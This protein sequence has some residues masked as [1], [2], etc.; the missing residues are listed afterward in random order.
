MSSQNRRPVGAPASSGGQFAQSVR[1]ESPAADQPLT[2]VAADDAR[3]ANLDDYVMT[4]QPTACPQCQARSVNWEDIPDGREHHTCHNC[5]YEYLMSKDFDGE[6]QC[7]ICREFASNEVLEA[8][9][10]RCEDCKF[11]LTCLECEENFIE[12]EGRGDWCADCADFLGI[13][14]EGFPHVPDKKCWECAEDGNDTP[15]TRAD[16]N[17]PLCDGCYDRRVEDG[18]IESDEPPACA[19]CGRT[20]LVLGGTE[21]CVDCVSVDI[22]NYRSLHDGRM[23][24]REYPMAPPTPPQA[25]CRGCGQSRDAD[26]MSD[27]ICSTC[28]VNGV[29]YDANRSVP[30]TREQA[31]A[32][33][34]EKAEVIE[35]PWLQM[36][37]VAEHARGLRGQ[38]LVDKLGDDLTPT[39][40]EQ[41]SKAAGVI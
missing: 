39:E 27:G 5:H 8:N 30:P 11:T 6:E 14:E 16:D 7:D 31:L 32:E 22:H 19:G 36:Q 29:S 2:E 10:G 37:F 17:G 20:G 41:V 26:A 33:A 12:Y 28:F 18:L 13:S 1:N 9:Q 23:K 34:T 25:T 38:A 3:F 24:R 21:K 40:H 35:Q 4:D 15:A